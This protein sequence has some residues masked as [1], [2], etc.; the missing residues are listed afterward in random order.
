MS[1]VDTKTYYIT[2][3]QQ[4]TELELLCVCNFIMVEIKWNGML[5]HSKRDEFYSPKF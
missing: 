4:I 1:L 5:L 3:V 2:F